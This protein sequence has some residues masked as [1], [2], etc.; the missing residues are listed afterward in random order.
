MMLQLL[1]PE[2]QQR[3]IEQTGDA[4]RWLRQ[5]C[6]A[7]RAAVRQWERESPLRLYMQVLLLPG[8]TRAI[9]PSMMRIRLP[10]TR[11][12]HLH[13]ELRPETYGA[14]LIPNDEDETLMHQFLEQRCRNEWSATVGCLIRAVEKRGLQPQYI[15]RW[16]LMCVLPVLVDANGYQDKDDGLSETQIHQLI[17]IMLRMR[18]LERFRVCMLAS[19]YDMLQPEVWERAPLRRCLR[20]VLPQWSHLTHLSLTDLSPTKSSDETH[21]LVHTLAVALTRDSALA[22]RLRDIWQAGGDV[23]ADLE[24]VGYPSALRVLELQSVWLCDDGDSSG[25]F[26]LLLGAFPIERLVLKTTRIRWPSLVHDASTQTIFIEAFY[27]WTDVARVTLDLR[28][29]LNQSDE[30]HEELLL[31]LFERADDD[32][33]RCRS[34]LH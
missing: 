1:L 24:V 12:L 21:E 5:T 17:R 13:S 23:R 16:T 2:L 14:L 6:R 4:R 27:R 7:L 32:D 29:Q 9:M 28:G 25:L 26:W 33:H 8:L 15:T 30:D 34:M 19:Q 22:R 3:V 31:S 20:A 10:T 11:V 18:A